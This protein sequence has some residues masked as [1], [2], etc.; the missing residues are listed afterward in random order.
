M[1]RPTTS[2]IPGK[3]ATAVVN[4]PLV[5]EV[6]VVLAA[7]AVEAAVG[8]LVV[9]I[10]AAVVAGVEAAAAEVGAA[11]PAELATSADTVALNCPVIE[12]KTNLAEKD[13]YGYCGLVVSLRPME[14]NLTK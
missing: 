7:E 10:P 1:T 4:A 2:A 3:P 5:L 12:P 11:T 6:T 14:V 9:L 13:W 8:A